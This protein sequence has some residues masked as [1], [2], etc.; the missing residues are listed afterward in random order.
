[1]LRDDYHFESASVERVLRFFELVRARYSGPAPGLLQIEDRK[2]DAAFTASVRD[3][4]V[5]VATLAYHDI[6]NP[7]PATLD[8]VYVL[9][10]HRGRGLGGM[11][12]EIAIRW[13]IRIGRRPVL[14]RATSVGMQTVLHRFPNDLQRQMHVRHSANIDTFFDP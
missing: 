10:E 12:S 6:D 13:C 7:E 5:G 8:T 9:P 1:M 14:C 2:L 11:L 4:I 3:E